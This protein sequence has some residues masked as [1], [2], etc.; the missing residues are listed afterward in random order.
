M[1]SGIAGRYV[2]D[3]FTAVL[4]VVR[5]Q[6][7]VRNGLVTFLRDVQ[8]SIMPRQS[9]WRGVTIRQPSDPKNRITAAA[10]NSPPFAR[11]SPLPTTFSS[12]SS[13]SWKLRLAIN[14]ADSSSGSLTSD[15]NSI[16]SPQNECT[17]AG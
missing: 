10:S 17:L 7:R 15:T 14:F 6:F 12:Y 2:G 4:D 8:A 16:A 5:K 3:Y 1:E 13:P 9:P 11:V